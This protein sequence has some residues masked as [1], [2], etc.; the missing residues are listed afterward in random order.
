MN[1]GGGP[2]EQGIRGKPGVQRG[3]QGGGEESGSRWGNPEEMT[4]MSKMREAMSILQES[5]G[6]ISDDIHEKLLDLGLDAEEVNRLEEMAKSFN[7]YGFEN[8]NNRNFIGQ[9]ERNR[10][11]KSNDIGGTNSVNPGYAI[12]IGVLVLLVLANTYLLSKFKRRY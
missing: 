9:D 8:R 7:K 10:Q 3:I 5:G 12:V 2:G 11:G 1:G 6:Q 4:D